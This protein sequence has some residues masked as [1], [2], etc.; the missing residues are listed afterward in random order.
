MK[1][2][3]YYYQ[4]EQ[5]IIKKAK[6]DEKELYRKIAKADFQLKILYYFDEDTVTDIF[7]NNNIDNQDNIYFSVYLRDGEFLGCVGIQNYKSPLPELA[8]TLIEEYQGK[9]FGSKLIKEWLN[10]IYK[11]FNYRKIQINID[12][13]NIPSIKMFEKLNVEK[14]NEGKFISYHLNLPIE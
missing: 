9:G 14:D 10:W 6:D 4:S 2:K 1:E 11:E 7:W 13:D 3:E 12:A 8:I 5:F